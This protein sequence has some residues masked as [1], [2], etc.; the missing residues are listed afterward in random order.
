MKVKSIFFIFLISAFFSACANDPG[1]DPNE[2]AFELHFPN[3]SFYMT[4]PPDDPS[5]DDALIE[6]IGKQSSAYTMEVCLYGLDRENVLAA[7][8]DAIAGGVHVR[9]VGN[10]DSG[11]DYY[12]G[13]TRI[14]RAL[15]DQFGASR[16]SDIEA[17]YS[18]FRL[19]NPGAIMH[20]KFIIVTAEGGDQYLFTGTTNTTESGFELNNNNSIIFHNDEIADHYR[21]QFE[22]LLGVSEDPVQTAGSFTIDGIPVEVYFS[23]YDT[24]GVAAIQHIYNLADTADSSLHFLIFS[25]PYMPLNYLMLDKF[26]AGLDVK[27]VIDE[28]QEMNC[29]EEFLAQQGVPLRIDGNNN[30]SGLHGGKLHH[31]TMI[32]DSGQSDA[33]VV[34]GSFNWSRN[35]DEN[36]DE[37]FLFIHSKKVAEFYEDEFLRRWEEAT[38]VPVVENP[39]DDAIAGDVVISEV[40]WMGSRANDGTAY[41]SQEF[42]ELKNN[43]GSQIDLSAWII[44]GAAM[45][46]KPVILPQATFILPDEYLVIMDSYPDEGSYAY[47]PQYY[48]VHDQ[49]S[50]SNDRLELILEDP[51]RTEIDRAGEGNEGVDFAGISESGSDGNKMSMIR[52]YPWQDGS[53]YASWSDSVLQVS[54]DSNFTDHTYGS[55]GAD[56]TSGS[57][58]YNE[59][60]VV[61]SEVAWAGTVAST[62]DEWIEIYNN[63]ASDITFNGIWDLN[64]ADSALVI[65]LTGK[66]IPA[67]G[68]FLLERTDDNSV[69][70]LTADCIYTNALGNTGEQLVLR[71]GTDIIDQTPESPTGTNWAAGTKSPDYLTMERTDTTS[72]GSLAG[73]WANGPGD[74]EGAQNSGL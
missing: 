27:G 71:Y 20:N 9:F 22:F 70:G 67:G 23:P 54:I 55:P 2:N 15:D 1:G 8:E 59:R 63:T 34:T 36:N 11:G 28:S 72:D 51:D 43:T 52:L 5:M 26:N 16:A 41:S 46:G 62:A 21:A 29:A 74:T 13:Y 12:A 17:D 4:N 25:F 66:T 3:I 64:T 69:P 44:H 42:V 19:V 37:N 61:I 53:L 48:R 50:I 6:M 68:Y 65:S 10:R 40:M 47:Y 31:K 7:I 49:L 35:A 18:D 57:V 60:D 38:E 32:I 33:V 14:A 58:S 73:S 39:G 56:N 45:S 24:D 30:S